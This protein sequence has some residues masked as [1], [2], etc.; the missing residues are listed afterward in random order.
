[1]TREVFDDLAAE[2]PAVRSFFGRRSDRIREDLA[3]A[4]LHASAGDPLGT[5]VRDLLTR[6]AVTAPPTSTVRDAARLMTE[7]RVS[8]LL[9]VDAGVVV[10]SL[11]DRDIRT[12]VV[13]EGLD[14]GETVAAAMTRSPVTVD[15]G[16]RAFD[17]TLTLIEHRVHHLPVV[18]DDA[19]VGLVTSADL[20]RLAQADPV[21]LAARLTRAP[22]AR[23]CRVSLAARSALAPD[24]DRVSRHA[25]RLRPLVTDFVRPRTAPHHI[26]RVS[27]ATADAATRRLLALAEEELGPPH[28][29]YCWVVLG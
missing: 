5:P 9:V 7:R 1:M 15:A 28:V 16:A 3:S 4:R 22:P 26:G 8:S 12:K 11:T 6:D 24:A 2:F 17:A 14:T 29:G 27:T 18:D 19:P 23:P 13:A 10:G 25:E 21:Y 20:L